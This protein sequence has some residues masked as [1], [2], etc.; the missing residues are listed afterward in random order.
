MLKY[1]FVILLIFYGLSVF[2]QTGV[3]SSQLGPGWDAQLGSRYDYQ[4]HGTK[5]RVQDLVR[6]GF[7]VDIFGKFELVGVVGSG[8]SFSS[9]W[10]TFKDLKN[11][12]STIQ[13]PSIHF[14]QLYIQKTSKNALF[15]FG[16]I[17]TV[18]KVV[19]AT[20][21]SDY[22]WVDGARAERSF[23]RGIVGVVVGSIND[24]NNP[25]A[26]THKRSL[27]FFE[28]EVTREFFDHL[29][30]E[31]TFER[32]QDNN[33]IQ[34]QLKYDLEKMGSKMVTF[35]TEYLRDLDTGGKAYTV[36]A[37]ADLL[38]LLLNRYDG[39]LKVAVGFSYVDPKLGVR[40]Q[41]ND[42]FVSYGNQAQIIL[43][44]DITN[45]GRLGWVSKNYIGEISRFNVGVTLKL[46][47]KKNAIR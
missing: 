37:E 17:P 3:D 16:T 45:N 23:D 22:G 18:S 34:G 11:P 25:N 1:T 21:L 46:G 31:L 27:N 6:M 33:Y 2:A 9:Q 24:I 35:T 15:Q 29:S 32:F 36:S 26:F 28:V 44:G 19:S 20:G 4:N 5:N 47:R 39:R 38:H 7:T 30:A 42:E 14:R 10:Q 41:L 8:D 13:A 43:R 12:E 40:G